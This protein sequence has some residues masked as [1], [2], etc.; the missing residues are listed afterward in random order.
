MFNRPGLRQP[1]SSWSVTF[2]VCP[3]QASFQSHH[4]STVNSCPELCSATSARACTPLAWPLHCDPFPACFWQLA[5]NL[6]VSTGNLLAR[7]LQQVLCTAITLAFCSDLKGRRLQDPALSVDVTCPLQAF[8]LKPA[9][10]WI[11]AHQHLLANDP[12]PQP[13]YCSDLRKGAYTVMTQLSA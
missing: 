2:R 13:Q 9:A 8:A 6:A 1:F 7:P 12:F 10:D 5:E 11:S 3:D 4:F